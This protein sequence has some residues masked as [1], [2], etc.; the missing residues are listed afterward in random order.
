MKEQLDLIKILKNCPKG[1][2]FYSRCLGSVEFCKIT[3][4]NY[5]EVI[6]KN[7]Y[8]IGFKPN[9]T[10]QHSEETAEIDLFPSKDQRDWSKWHRPFVNG[11]IVFYNDTIAIFKEWGDETLFRTYVAKGLNCED[12]IGINTPL[13]G[14]SVRN[15]IRFATEEEKQILFKAL[16]DNGYKWNPETKTLKNWTIQD[17]KDGDVIFYD[18]GWTCI[19]KCIHGIWYSSYCF[20]TCDGEF[21]T[22]YEEHDVDSKI[23]GNAHIA[24]KEQRDF[25]FQKI[26]EAGYKWNSDV[27][28]LEKLIVPKFKVGD[29]VQSKTDNNDK[30]TITN[31]DNNKFYYGCGNGH[32][33]MIPV[34]KQ[35]NWELVPNKTT[36]DM[37]EKKINQMSLANC[38]LDEVEIVLGDRFE[39]KIKDNKYYAVRKK[40]TYPKT[41]EECCDVI[42]ISRH[43]VEI[44]VPRPYQQNMFNLFKLLI[45]RDAYWKIVGEELGLDKPWKPVWDESEDLYTIHTFNGEIRLSGTAHRNAILVF[46]IE[47]IRDMFYDNFKTLIEQCKELL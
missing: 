12:L 13:F 30:F 16:E 22:G 20:I 18:D 17:A 38:D 14:K 23:N 40:L 31:I 32:E 37:G 9:G 6:G 34:V 19:F 47:E 26:K 8:Y 46:P 39:L 15:E 44:D 29:S 5:I 25:L 36:K 1:T 28:K 43:E 11:D 27:K 42:G 35:D 33:F 3:L 41:Y 7:G 45:C 21:H 2:K 4:D 10:Y 24:T